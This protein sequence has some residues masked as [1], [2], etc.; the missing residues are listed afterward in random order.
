MH[1]SFFDPKDQFIA[2][3]VEALITEDDMIT[4]FT[5]QVPSTGSSF[6]VP[7]PAGVFEDG[8]Y[9][10]HV[11]YNTVPGANTPVIE[12]PNALRTST[13]FGISTAGT[14]DAGTTLDFI[15]RPR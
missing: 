8:D 2:V 14:L 11:A 10:V 5:Y 9:T 3:R 4:N 13:G 12:V 7:L 1:K 15:V 6:T